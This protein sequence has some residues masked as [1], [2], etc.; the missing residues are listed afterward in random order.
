MARNVVPQN[1]FNFPPFSSFFDEDW[2]QSMQH[3]SQVGRELQASGLELSEDD[4]YVYVEVAVPGE[5][6]P[7]TQPDASYANG[8]IRITFAKAPQPKQIAINVDK[9]N[10]E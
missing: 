7:N 3:M 6:D 8:M 2:L 1:F 4:K 5:F 9:K 10:K